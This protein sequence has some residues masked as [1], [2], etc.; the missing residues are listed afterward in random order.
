MD[1]QT[2][3]RV[4]EKNIKL[5]GSKIKGR[6]IAD[7]VIMPQSGEFLNQILYNNRTHKGN[8]HIYAR[9]SKFDVIVLYEETLTS[10]VFA[11]EKDP[12]E[13]VLNNLRKAV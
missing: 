1:Y 10:N 6:K 4:R 12:L 5:I 3:E 11:V 9:F 8:E 2:A 13:F 7:L